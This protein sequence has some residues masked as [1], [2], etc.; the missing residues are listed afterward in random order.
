MKFKYLLIVP[1]LVVAFM[2]FYIVA[3]N[4]EAESIVAL[5]SAAQADPG[6]PVIDRERLLNDVRTL[7]APAFE[8]RQ[9]GSEGSRK[10]Q[11]WLAG[12]FAEAGIAPY[13]GSYLHPFSYT[14]TS[15]KGLVLPGRPFQTV[16]PNAVNIVGHIR[17]STN[18]SRVLLVSAHYDHLGVREGKVYPGADDNASGVGAMLA[19]AAWFKAHPPQHTI[20]FAAF[21]AEEA[22]LRG[23]SALLDK[24]PFPR[25]QL[26]MNLN[27]D[28]VSHNDN[29]EIYVAGT[30]Y[31]PVL[32]ALVAQAAARSAVQVKPGHDKAALMSPGAEDWTQGSD[33]GVF[34]DAGLP[35]LY[36]GV[37][38]HAH[39][40]H[41]GDTFEH[42]NQDFYVKVASLL[43]DVAA[44]LDRQL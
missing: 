8:G 27:L 44:I 6:A 21:D 38:D 5:P 34:H 15:I 4:Q 33:H 10:A 25:E 42:I 23:A 3:G 32:K 22:G 9:T 2:I 7:A 36:F 18:P 1:L 43:I 40:H 37:E 13:G 26:V 12:R 16:V 17:G 29:N 30:S 19:I 20:V 24:P 14:K 41:P 31:T 28:M 11:A 39:Y 35:F